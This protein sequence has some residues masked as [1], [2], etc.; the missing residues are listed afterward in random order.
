MELMVVLAI[1]AILSSLGFYMFDA[2][3]EREKVLDATNTIQRL[4]EAIEAY[5]TKTLQYPPELASESANGSGVLAGDGY[6]P[7]LRGRVG[8][9]RRTG[10]G[11]ALT[12]QSLFFYEPKPEFISATDSDHVLDVWGFPIQYRLCPRNTQDF[13][14]RF[15]TIL[16]PTTLKNA[17][18]NFP[19]NPKKYNL[20]SPGKDGRDDGQDYSGPVPNN[21]YKSG[22]YSGTDFSEDDIGN[23]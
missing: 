15:Y 2:A 5:Y 18:L 22:G 6:L 13:K 11:L 9:T 21:S 23:W 3:K 7:H 4:S 19:G 10:V 14:T 16:D 17:V 12:S 1:V 8:L 20:W